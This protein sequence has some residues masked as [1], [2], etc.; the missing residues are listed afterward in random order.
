MYS[1]YL[2][3]TCDL[4]TTNWRNEMREHAVSVYTPCPEDKVTNCQTTR[5][6]K[7]KKYKCYQFD[8]ELPCCTSRDL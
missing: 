6:P 8:F 2:F 4:S 5:N 3:N 1:T 7:K